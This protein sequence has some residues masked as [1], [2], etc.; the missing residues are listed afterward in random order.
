MPVHF[1]QPFLP[2]VDI[3]PHVRSAPQSDAL[4]VDPQPCTVRWLTKARF[5]GGEG[6]T[7]TGTTAVLVVLGPKKRRERIPSVLLAGHGEIGQQGDGLASIHRD[8]HAVALDQ[9]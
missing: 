2:H 8:G 1:R 9:W 6:A 7:Q 4:P 5:E 3:D